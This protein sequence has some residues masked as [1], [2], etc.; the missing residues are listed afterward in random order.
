MMI[1]IL[2]LLIE[3]GWWWRGPLFVYAMYTFFYV[4]TK[5][6]KV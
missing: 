4:L 5:H 2:G 3:E 6:M 1:D